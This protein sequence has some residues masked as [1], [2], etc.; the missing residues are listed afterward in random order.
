MQEGTADS[1]RLHLRQF[2][3]ESA[4]SSSRMVAEREKLQEG[5]AQYHHGDS[6][7]KVLKLE[8]LKEVIN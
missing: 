4:G 1:T 2:S 6:R 8:D 3:Q 5:E 7:Q